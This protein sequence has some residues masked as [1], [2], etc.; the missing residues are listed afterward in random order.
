MYSKVFRGNKFKFSNKLLNLKINFKDNLK[1]ISQILKNKEINDGFSYPETRVKI[2]GFSLIKSEYLSF[3]KKKILIILK[4]K[5][6]SKI[7]I[8]WM[9]SYINKNHFFYKSIEITLGYSKFLPIKLKKKNFSQKKNR[10]HNFRQKEIS[11]KHILKQK[12]L[13]K[14]I[15]G[16]KEI[17]MVFFLNKIRKNFG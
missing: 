1:K 6:D 11:C 15:K 9:K 8:F 5:H 16:K 7:K 13:I 17:T 4:R 10:Q 2:F 12:N 14:K 3:F